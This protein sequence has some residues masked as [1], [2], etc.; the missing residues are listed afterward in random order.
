M[1]AERQLGILSLA[2]RCVRPGGRLVYATCSLC[3]TE[4]EAV[5]EGFLHHHPAFRPG[6]TPNPLSLSAAAGPGHYILP[7]RFNGDGFYV[8][9]LQRE[10]PA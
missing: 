4:N 9:I 5:I 3:R 6:E 1:Q 8:A 2:A 7:E 10:T